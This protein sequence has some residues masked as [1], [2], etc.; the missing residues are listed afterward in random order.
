MDLATV[1]TSL[2]ASELNCSI[3]C[4]WDSGWD[5]KLGDEL[6]GFVAEG[7][8]RTPEEIA[9][10]LHDAAMKSSRRQITRNAT[11]RTNDPTPFRR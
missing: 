2:Y 6:N 3:S 10:F 8:V 11:G 4:I 7:N 5:V 1:L 9:S